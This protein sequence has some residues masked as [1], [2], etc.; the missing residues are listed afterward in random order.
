M[1]YSIFSLAYQAHRGWTPA[2]RDASPEPSYDV[3]IIGGGWH[4]LATAY[5]LA[6]NFG[7]RR[8]QR[9]RNLRLAS[10]RHHLAAG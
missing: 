9:S 5:Y 4:G 7:I 1:H 6:K 10:R 3:I 2:W 8:R